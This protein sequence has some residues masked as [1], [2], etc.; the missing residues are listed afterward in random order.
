MFNE[1]QK[2]IISTLEDKD[3][4]ITGKELSSL[5]NV[6]LRTI[7]YEIANINKIEDIIYSSNRGYKINKIKLNSINLIDISRPD[8][9]HLILKTILMTSDKQHIYDLS[10]ELFISTSSLEARLSKIQD[11]LSKYSL[12]IDR[13]NNLIS[14]KGAEFNKRRLINNLIFQEVDNSF[15]ENSDILYNSY[16][17]GMDVKRIRTIIINS[18]HKFDFYVE[19]SYQSNL[20][21]NITIALYRMRM[22]SYIEQNDTLEFDNK[23]AEFKIAEEICHQYALHWKIQ[24]SYRDINYVAT[25][26]YGQTKPITQDSSPDYIDSLVSNSFLEEI[27]QIVKESLNYYM[28][29]FN[30]NEFIYNFAL[31]IDS[32]IKRAKSNQFESNDLLENIKKNCP[33]IYD[34]AVAITERI[35]NK[36]NIHINDEEIGYISIHIGFLIEDS[37][38]ESP[39]LNV[40]LN[41]NEYQSISETLLKKLGNE[42]SNKIII[43]EAEGQLSLTQFRSFDLII[44]TRPL[45]IIGLNEVIISPFF[46]KDDKLKLDKSITSALSE[47][48]KQSTNNLLNNYF[49]DELFFINDDFSNKFD[50]IKFLGKQLLDQHYVDDSFVDSVIKR[51]NTSSTCFFDTFAIPHAIEL[52]AT[53]TVFCVLISKKGIQWDDNTIHIV[54]M[55]AVQQRDRKEFMNIY[56]GVIRSLWDQSKLNSLV[57]V[58]SFDEFVSILKS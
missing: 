41:A 34:V 38:N 16:F 3:N 39:T 7:Q 52:N 6:S 19:K 57:Q 47:K 25:L 18:L 26:L 17:Q 29:P 9:T 51:E 53:K 8:D 2:K 4:E 27:R 30:N 58:N 21:I 55:I 14:I 43:T 10:E 35:S 48:E 54:L 50:V 23:H 15:H 24:P 1:R 28:I 37:N 45:G 42:Y 44:S 36:Y 33:F 56:N 5:L 12:E 11:I 46:T 22:N 20:F 32:L 13:S 49:F 31:H 40:L